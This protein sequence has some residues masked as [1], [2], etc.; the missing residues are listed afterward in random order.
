MLKKR[1]PITVTAAYSYKGNLKSRPIQ[2]QACLLV[3]VSHVSL[4]RYFF[5]RCVFSDTQPRSV[6]ATGASSVFV[7][8][9]MSPKSDAAASVFVDA[10]R[11]GSMS[12]KRH[13]N[14]SVFLGMSLFN[15]A[16]FFNKGIWIIW[17]FQY[18][19]CFVI[20]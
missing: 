9:Q 19:Y 6:P 1:A 11:T 17:H 5:S 2:S 12:P 15:Q 13:A 10:R 20:S 16:S 7:G 8:G 18:P 4:E 14:A 3:K